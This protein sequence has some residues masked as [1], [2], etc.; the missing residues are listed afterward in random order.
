[1]LHVA[2]HLAA[3]GAE[4]ML[5]G[6]VRELDVSG[7]ARSIVCTATAARADRGLVAA[8][9]A[10]SVRAV[11]LGRRKLYDPRLLGGLMR[12]ARRHDV[13]IVHSHPGTVNGH[14]RLAAR[15]LGLPHVT[16]LHTVPGPEIE[17]SRPTLAV[18]RWTAGLS[19]VFVAPSPTVAT[20]YARS[21]GLPATRFR[22][23]PNMP[24]ASRPPGG[25]DRVAARR[26]LGAREPDG[27]IVVCLARLEPA[28][29]ID[30]LVR[31]AAL[32]RRWVP[33]VRVVVAGAGPEQRALRALVAELG[34]GETVALVGH[35][36]DVGE[37]LA[38][39]DAFCLPSRHEGLPVS[40]LEAMDAGLPCVVTSVGGLPDL[41][42]DGRTGLLVA[43]GAV[44]D[45]AAALR[46]VVSDPHLAGRLG[47]AAQAIVARHHGPGVAAAGYGDIYDE[48]VRHADR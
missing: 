36:D 46:R 9:T 12:L 33:G 5:A 23:V 25:F 31:A 29:A 35:R 38:A 41:V 19:D 17:D 8:V 16:T 26:A 39:A 37:L 32:V 21:R 22:I 20:A 40:V 14:A 10:H 13:Q 42:R 15:A 44:D 18:D 3:G 27:R 48:L 2:D 4:R 6:L 34:L 30:D 45:L 47:A 7:R 11:T 28:K 1:M 24:A 43:P